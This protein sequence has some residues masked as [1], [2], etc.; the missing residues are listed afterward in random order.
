[1]VQVKTEL[2]PDAV[3]LHTSE[4]KVGGLFGFF[5]SRMVQVMAAVEDVP[6][7]PSPKAPVPARI[8]NPSPVPASAASA[9]APMP[10]PAPLPEPAPMPVP[11]P[12]P[13]AAPL[14]RTQAAAAAEEPGQLAGELADMKAMMGQIMERIQ[15]P[16][17]A[18]RMEPEVRELLAALLRGGV[19]ETTALGLISRVR[20][21]LTRTGTPLSNCQAVAREI[22]LKQMDQ[23]HTVEGC[24]R[25][26]ALVGPTGVG[27][28]TTLAK[29]AAHLTLQQKKRV[30]LITAD[31]YRVAAVDQ[32]RTYSEILGTPLEVV[33]EASDIE[34]ALMRHWDRDVILV[35]TA[36]RSPRNEA[37]MN[38]LREYLEALQPADTFL[39]MSLTSSYRDAQTI[40][41]AYLPLRFDSFLFTKRDETD[42]PGLI[43]DMVTKYRRPLSYL[44]TGQ[45]VPDDLEVASP[46][47]IIRAILGD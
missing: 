14:P 44:T 10:E 9:P 11:A 26:V 3:I 36:G 33:Y 31:T 28:T 42:A 8:T 1:M 45:A 7:Q 43:Y 22:M 24:G 21:R 5:G 2:G 46:E 17:S 18:A 16:T 47:T 25:V 32:L 12:A 19:E 23:L 41:D 29:L 4:I 20:S 13:A 27:K 15:L 40:V 37:H 6:L 34:S 35:D 30:A 38:E 39:V